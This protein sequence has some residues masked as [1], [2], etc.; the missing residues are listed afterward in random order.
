MFAILNLK[1]TQEITD[2]SAVTSLL[3]SKQI[4]KMFLCLCVFLHI[5]C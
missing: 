1:E 2:N 5:K 3:P 4:F